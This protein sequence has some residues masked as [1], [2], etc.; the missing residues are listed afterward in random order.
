[1]AVGTVSRIGFLE[2]P[3]QPYVASEGPDINEAS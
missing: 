2:Q 3:P 1:M